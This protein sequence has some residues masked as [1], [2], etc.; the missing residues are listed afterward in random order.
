MNKKLLGFIIGLVVIGA[1]LFFLFNY[2]EIEDYE[3]YFQ[4]SREAQVNEYLAL[5]RWL[6]AEGHA[7]RVER[8]G[9]LGLLKEAAADIILIQERLFNWNE[10]AIIYLGS[11]V[12]QG[13]RLILCLDNYRGRYIDSFLQTYLNELGVEFGE[14][15][16]ELSGVWRY[17]P[18]FPV[19]G[20]NIIFKEPEDPNYEENILFLKDVYG[21]GRLMQFSRGSGSI[22]VTGNPRFMTS[23]NI[24]EESDSRLSWYLLAQN[25]AI[26]AGTEPSILFIRGDSPVENLLG[27]MFMLGNFRIIIIAGLILIIIGFWSFIPLFGVV[28]GSEEKTGRLL[29]ERFLAEGRFLKRFGALD[30]YRNTY[31]REIR[32][33][34]MKHE[35][36]SD[37]EIIARSANLLKASNEG[38]TAVE[39]AVFPG[40]QK[41]KNFIESI[42]TLRTI[43]ERI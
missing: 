11:W 3:R 36:L 5:D 7:V 30:N 29:A 20:R 17:D 40:R 16:D 34:F 24:S 33:K 2:Y 37:E 8:N 25:A 9:N 23:Y 18:N 38:I 14:E 43:L 39:K 26:P 28:R 35:N 22:T 4:P 27:R 1:A 21:Y 12:E 31:F 13:G 6:A 10:E 15:L 19:Y 41:S 42:K 32:R